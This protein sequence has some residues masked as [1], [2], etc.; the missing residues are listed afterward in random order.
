MSRN[1]E[2]YRGFHVILRALP[3]LLAA[4]PDVVMVGGDETS[5]GAPCPAGT[6]HQHFLGEMEGRLDLRRVFFLGK[7]NYDSY[8]S[9]LATSALHG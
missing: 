3:K 4:C 1:L 7:I 5:Y 8:W 2:P 9:L 6:W